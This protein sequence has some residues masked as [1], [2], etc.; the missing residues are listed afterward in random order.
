M[1]LLRRP[2][3]KILKNIENCAFFQCQKEDFTSLS[4]FRFQ[5]KAAVWAV[6]FSNWNIFFA[7]SKTVQMKPLNVTFWIFTVNHNSVILSA[8][9]APYFLL[10]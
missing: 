6:P 2:S 7:H 10:L 5:K 4:S 3:T 8:T 1:N 9:K